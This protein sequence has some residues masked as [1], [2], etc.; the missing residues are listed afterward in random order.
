MDIIINELS[1]I[2]QFQKK[3]DFVANITKLLPIFNIID[4]QGF[5]LL[6]EHAFFDSKITDIETLSS[7]LKSK[8]SNIRKIKSLLLK[9]ARNPPYWNDSRRHNCD[10]DTYSFNGNNICDTSLAEASQRDKIILSFEHVDYI[11]QE[12]T[13]KKNDVNQAIF[14]IVKKDTFLEKLYQD[15]LISAL[16]FCCFKFKKSNINFETLE[17]KF[18]FS[19]LNQEQTRNFIS[20]FDV[21]TSMTWCDI[22]KSS[23]KKNGLNYKSYQGDWF[24]GTLHQD[25][26]IKKFRVSQKY[27][28]FGYRENDIFNV[29][30]FEINHKNSDKG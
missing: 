27:R 17:K 29:L 16:K 7:I 6:K 23:S 18:G 28:C 22:D 12:L 8:N 13:I 10:S 4:K 5:G 1:L 30:R 24:N 9:L 11:N 3:D 21:F 15:K 26:S 14:N 25:K 19:G 20:S 2:G